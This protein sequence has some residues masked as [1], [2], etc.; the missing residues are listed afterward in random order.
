LSSYTGKKRKENLLTQSVGVLRKSCGLGNAAAVVQ[1]V[2][3]RSD[4]T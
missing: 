3:H 2:A 4:W 1:M